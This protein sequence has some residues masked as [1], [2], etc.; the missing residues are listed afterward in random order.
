VQQ[1]K[2]GAQPPLVLAI[3]DGEP[4]EHA[5][6]ALAQAKGSAIAVADPDRRI[7]IAYGVNVWPTIVS[8]DASGIISGIQLGYADVAHAARPTTK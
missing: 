8:I 4:A 1:T 5:H 2:D 7:A 6:R 3:N